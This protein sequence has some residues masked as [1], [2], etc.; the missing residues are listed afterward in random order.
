[1]K[2]QSWP[3]IIYFC[4]Q[5][6]TSYPPQIAINWRPCIWKHYLRIKIR[7]ILVILT[8]SEYMSVSEKRILKSLRSCFHGCQFFFKGNVWSVSDT[9]GNFSF[10]KPMDF[11]WHLL[12][13]KI[14]E[15][16]EWGGCWSSSS[17]LVY[18]EQHI[19]I[20]VP[21]SPEI[22]FCFFVGL[23]D[24]YPLSSFFFSWNPF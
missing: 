6:H 18:F 9:A 7:V 5:D 8:L 1:M 10:M 15:L 23:G 19:M 3:L 2:P 24:K 11:N 17:V 16:I 14:H 21:K 22:T 20:L 12:V 13:L 4:Q